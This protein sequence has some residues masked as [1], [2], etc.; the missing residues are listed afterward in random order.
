MIDP[1]L[2][3]ADDLMAWR[4][5]SEPLRF[6]SEKLRLKAMGPADHIRTKHEV[7]AFLISGERSV[8]EEILVRVRARLHAAQVAAIG[9]N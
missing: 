7:K 9:R 6:I 8:A 3:T 4:L 2:P 5:E 1:A